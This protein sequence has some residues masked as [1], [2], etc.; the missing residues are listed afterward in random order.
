M[1][2]YIYFY[3]II[4][5]LISFLKFVIIIFK[6]VPPKRYGLFL[7]IKKLIEIFLL[8]RLLRIRY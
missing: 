1:Q 2:I 8:L 3:N 5:V 6:K 7:F 4:F